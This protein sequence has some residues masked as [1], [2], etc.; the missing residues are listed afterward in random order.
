MQKFVIEDSFWDLFPEASVA[1]L[2]IRGM[3]TADEVS[4]DDRAAIEGLL[5]QANRDA[6]K[7]L[8]SPTLSENAPVKVWRD[9]YRRFKTKR[10]ARC[11]VENLFKRVLKD[12]PVG[13]ITPSV[14][15]YNIV[16]L[17]HAFPVG[18]ENINAFAG[19]LRLG[20]TE[21]GDAFRALGEEKD[22]PTL[23]GEVCYRDDEGA[24][25]RCL[26]WRDG[27]RTALAD[28]SR[29]AFLVIES[30]DPARADD[31]AAAMGDLEGLVSEYLSGTVCARGTLTRE[32][33]EMVLVD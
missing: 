4:G 12:R 19:D 21:G 2:V 29:D 16:S 23:E 13:P 5:E 25:C 28:D 27:Q 31:L 7:H 32:N 8:D 30:V 3:K 10:G 20:V 15:L 17:R 18:G 22:D 26:N 14:D 33:P 9:A 1:C 24:V 11:S 6:A